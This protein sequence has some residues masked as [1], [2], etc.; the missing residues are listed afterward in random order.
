[1]ANL[2]VTIA[3]IYGAEIRTTTKYILAAKGE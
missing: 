1:M 2:D 3:G